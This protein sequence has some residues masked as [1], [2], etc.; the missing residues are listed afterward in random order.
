[1]KHFTSIH[2]LKLSTDQ[3]KKLFYEVDH[4]FSGSVDYDGFVSLYYKLTNVQH[5]SLNSL[6]QVYS[7]DGKKILVDEL[8]KFFSDE[9]CVYLPIQQLSE[10]IFRNSIDSLRHYESNPYFTIYEFVDYL[11]SKENSIWDEANNVVTQDMKQ[12][13]NH[14]WI[15]SSHNTY[16]SGDQFKSESSVECYIRCLRNGCR[17]VERKCVF[18]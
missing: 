13:L 10:I 18:V 7:K 2:H 3:L 8:R 14:Y 17:C 5:P 11:F 15:A 12:P 1:M 16:L 4:N 6:I 9:Q